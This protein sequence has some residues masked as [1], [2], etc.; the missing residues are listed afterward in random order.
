MFSPPCVLSVECVLATPSHGSASTVFLIGV[1]DET[2]LGPGGLFHIAAAGHVHRHL[3][4]ARALGISGRRG[5]RPCAAFPRPDR[6]W[7]TMTCEPGMSF[8]MQPPLVGFGGEGQFVV[9]QVVLAHED[10]NACGRIKA[11]R[12]GR[13]Q[14][15]HLPAVVVF[16]HIAVFFQF[17]A[18]FRQI[19]L[20]HAGGE[21]E[22]LPFQIT[23]FLRGLF[24]LL[25][26]Q[27]LGRARLLIQLEVAL[28]VLARGKLFIKLHFRSRAR[29]PRNNWG[30]SR[31]SCPFWPGADW[32]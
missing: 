2:G 29:P 32:R 22:H 7:A 15:L 8:G 18:Q 31:S 21:V 20:L 26:G 13:F 11:H 9:L 10:G 3:A 27:A 25:G 5:G 24:H 12:P 23:Q 17:L 1:E 4:G 16:A 14:L 6:R 28:G 30:C 19:V